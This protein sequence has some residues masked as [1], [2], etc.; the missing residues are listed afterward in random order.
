MRSDEF[1][2]APQSVRVTKADV[3]SGSEELARL[4]LSKGSAAVDLLS[5]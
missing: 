1:R 3:A 4:L 5:R 2:R